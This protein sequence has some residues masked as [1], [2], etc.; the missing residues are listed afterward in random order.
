MQSRTECDLAI[1]GGGLAGGLIALAL[2]ERLPDLDGRRIESDAQRGGNHV[3]SFFDNDIAAEDWPLVSPLIGWRW[4]DNDVCFP[5]HRYTL[6]ATYNSIGSD[7]SNQMDCARL[8]PEQIMSGKAASLGPTIV[9]PDLSGAALHQLT[10]AYSQLH[11]SKPQ[12][13]SRGDYRMLDK[14]LGRATNSS[15]RYRAFKRFSTLA[16]GLIHRFFAGGLSIIDKLR[17]FSGKPLVSIDGTI[18]P[19]LGRKT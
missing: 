12:W 11:Y 19:I 16:Q 13:R 7:H 6:D 1:V 9:A 4:Q 14:I 18:G 5:A 15:E 2:K 10:H 3:W 8:E 17:I